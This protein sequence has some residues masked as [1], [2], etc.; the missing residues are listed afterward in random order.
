MRGARQHNLKNIDV[1][2][3]RRTFTVITG[4]SGSGKSSLAFDTI[5]AEGQ[6]RY[7]ESLSAYARQFLDR[8]EKPSVDSIEG[9]SPAVAI[10]QKNPTKTSRSTVGT[11]T[12]VYDYL[13]L[14]WA[15]VGR[16]FCP[17]CGR[18]MRPDTPQ[19]VADALLALPEGTRVHV[20]FPLHISDKLTDPVILENLRAAGFLRVRANGAVMH[21]DEIEAQG[22][23]LRKSGDLLVVVDRLVLGSDSA[24]RLAEAVSAAFA[25]GDGECFA[26]FADPVQT[27]LTPAPATELRFTDSFQ[28]AN[29]GTRMQPPTPQL[30]SFNS[31]RGACPR[32]NGFGAILE[33]DESLIVPYP[34]RTLK[35]GAIDPWSKPRYDN[36]RRA[37]SEFARRERIPMDAA[38]S[39]LSGAQQRQLLTARSRGY[40]GVIPFLRDLETKR[41]KQYIRVFLRQYQTAQ[42][43]PDC[44][45]SK[46]Q[47]EALN[48]RVGGRSI[49]EVSGMPV[50]ELR[51][52]LDELSLS[53]F[54]RA[55]AATALDEA[56][57]RVTFLCDV[58][59]NYLSLHRATRTL[60][61]GEAQRISLANSLGS[62]LVDTLYV[63]DEPSIGLHSRDMSR[64]LRLLHKLRDGGNSVLVVE[65]DPAAIE[66]ADYMIEL[67]PG[68]GEQGGEVV[69]AGPISRVRE[70]PLT[71]QYMTGERSI[72]LPAERRR[73][74]PRWITIT[75][76]REHNL[77]DVD[78]R[79]PLGTLTVVTGVSGSG[80][81]TL[82][83]DVLYRALENKLHG[84]HTAKQHLGE[85]VG[86]FD[87]ITGYDALDDVVLVDQS[88]IGRTPRSNPVTYVKAF[89]EIR[90]IFAATPL[91]RER[92]YT[93]G[94]FSFNVAGG[95]CETCE[96][97]GA[98]EVEMV[99]MA[100]VF[101]P[102]EDCGGKR[103]K[104]EVLEVRVNGRNVHEVLDLTVDQAIRFF[105]REEKLGQMLWHVQQVGLGYVRLGQ[106]A[107]TLSGGEAQRIK[108]ARELSQSAKRSGR[109]LY[110][111]DEPTTG[112]HLEDIRK[113]ALVLERL[114]DHGHTLVLI[115]HNLDVIK[116]ADWVID[117][118][119]EGGDRGG[120]IVAT[121]TPEDVAAV[122]ESYTGQWLKPLLSKQ[123]SLMTRKT[124]RAS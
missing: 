124:I 111:M 44:G 16:A 43:C 27:S 33:Y 80:K 42:E 21:L 89:D 7:V 116:L 58:G 29:D 72:P 20:A 3:P 13:R 85:R 69:F 11:A 17:K 47:P 59:L 31:P 82:I 36:K 98:L 35:A 119:P 18:E 39:D 120:M 37:L 6:R 95:R 101:V 15:R 9:L 90:R 94:T 115:E 10:E 65:H 14:L 92:R 74:G 86:E 81:S 61:G 34:E 41:Y 4:P 109:K 23:S 68:S 110:V 112:L 117:L 96:G 30:F 46:L 2:I 123:R 121:G 99:F 60:S 107:T 108:I 113:L 93:P 76:A 122:N 79:I 70:S 97:A 1:E 5:Y 50:D 40:K 49:A 62:K 26:L 67:G 66:A 8:M 12:E 114:V 25:E 51:V 48:V 32:C 28:C 73:A 118:G 84:E 57:G 52:W 63:L 54:E 64:L 100:D 105:A 55:V 22:L 71:G 45:G 77:R 38:W 83:H 102:C 91:A 56:R 104:S 88:P 24:T 19:S 53:D 78:I 106:P 103:F 87:T 75:G